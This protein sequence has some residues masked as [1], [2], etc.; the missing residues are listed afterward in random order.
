MVLIFILFMVVM[1]RFVIC[2]VRYLLSSC[3]V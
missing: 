2:C 1:D 3:S